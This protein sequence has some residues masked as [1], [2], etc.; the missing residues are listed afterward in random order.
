MEAWVPLFDVFLNSPAPESE[1]SQWLH[2][3][4]SASL[5]AGAPITTASFVSLLM[6][7]FDAIVVDESSSSS[8]SPPSTTRV[9]FVQTLPNMV[10]TRILSFLAV[11][12]RRFCRRDLCKLARNVLSGNQELDFWVERAAR[13]LLD[14]VSESSYEWISCLS[15]DSGEKRLED[16]FESLPGWLKDAAGTGDLLPWLPVLPEDLNSRTSYGD[17]VRNE[18]TLDQVNGDL[19]EFMDEVVGDVEIDDPKSDPLGPEIRNRALGLKPRIMNFESTSKVVGLANEIRELCSYKSRDS[20]VVLELIE[21]WLVDDETASVLISQLSNGSEEELTWPS[22]VLCSI[23]LPKFLVLEEPAPRVLLAATIEY[24]KLHQKTAVYALLFPLIFRKNGVNNPIC[25]VITRVI[26][27][28]LHPAHVSAIC[29]K[30]LCGGKDERRVICLPCHRN[31]ISDEMVWTESL[32]HLFQSILNHNV[33]L[34]QDS[35]DHIV[36][37]VLHSAERFSKSLKFGNFL[38]CLVTKCSP[39]LKSHKRILTEAVERTNTIV[40]KSLLSKLAVM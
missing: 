12:R 13:H 27:E 23:I 34:T 30:L 39:L 29:Q 3:S 40:T 17:S 31:L 36:Y 15:L 10:Q 9:M 38:L 2:Q 18:D 22:Q 25:D 8:S 7:P 33:C 1:A 11:E 4:F 6:K 35:V 24:S 16:E 32:F 21:P 14:A 5:S 28:C 37:Q 26:K 19:E 20:S